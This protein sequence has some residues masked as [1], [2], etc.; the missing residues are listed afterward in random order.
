MDI[1]TLKNHLKSNSLSKSRSITILGSTGSVGSN[2]VEL[3]Q[4]NL[5]SFTVEAL[6]MVLPDGIRNLKSPNPK[7]S[8]MNFLNS[9]NRIGEFLFRILIEFSFAIFP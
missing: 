7:L 2:T 6:L 4:N 3:I 1:N 9:L 8:I 5:D